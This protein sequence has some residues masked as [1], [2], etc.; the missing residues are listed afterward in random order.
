MKNFSV[1]T[2]MFYFANS[3]KQKQKNLRHDRITLQASRGERCEAFHLLQP[4]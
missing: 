1:S 3:A 2:V 4:K